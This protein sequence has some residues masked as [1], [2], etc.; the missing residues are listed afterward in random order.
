MVNVYG[1]V[2]YDRKPSFLV[3]LQHKVESCEY[4]IMLGG[5]FNLIR[6]PSEKSSADGVV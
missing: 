2:Q 4:P 6:N 3:E 5:D 1:P